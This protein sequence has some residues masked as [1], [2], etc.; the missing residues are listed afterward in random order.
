VG[1]SRRPLFYLIVSTS[2]NIALDLFFVAVLGM[3]V[4]GVALATVIA[5]LVSAVMAVRALITTT[6]SYRLIPG[7]LRIDRGMT[8][9]ILKIGMP[10]GV[11]QALVSLSN[12]FVNGYI[13]GLGTNVMAG[14]NA[15]MRLDLLVALPLQSLQLSAATFFGQNLGAGAVKRAKSGVK[16]VQMMM[17]GSAFV[18]EGILLLFASPLLR[19]FTP[20]LDVIEAGRRFIMILVPFY[21]ILTF[22]MTYSGAL[23]G[24]GDA[25]SPMFVQIACFVIMRQI[26]LF[27]GT[28]ISNTIEVVS[29][30]YPLTWFVAAIALA[31]IYHRGGWEA[32][33]KDKHPAIVLDS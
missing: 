12:L 28:R 30:G 29:V 13:N 18:T 1:D 6:E 3:G 23:R 19:V 31:A 16:Q 26:Y 5:S 25:R 20:D 17:L 24:S 11:Q 2:I 14:Y 7:Q 10:A 27:V 22:T 4:L 33:W 32:K 8:G 15:Y 21:F 9:E